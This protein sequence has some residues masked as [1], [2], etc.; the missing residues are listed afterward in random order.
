MYPRNLLFVTRMVGAWLCIRGS[1]RLTDVLRRSKINFDNPNL[2]KIWTKTFES[3][4]PNITTKL[5]TK[6]VAMKRF[7]CALLLGL[8][9]IDRVLF[10]MVWKGEWSV[11]LIQLTMKYIFSTMHQLEGKM[12]DWNITYLT[13]T[14]LEIL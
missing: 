14:N 9:I 2:E 12:L 5:S 13:S 10:N 8:D 1:K 3:F 11:H 7:F 4:Y 6:T